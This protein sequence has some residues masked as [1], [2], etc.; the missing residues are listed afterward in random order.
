MWIWKKLRKGGGYDENTL[1]FL[2]VQAISIALG[3]CPEAEGEFPL[4]KIPCT[5]DTGF[6][7][8]N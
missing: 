6:R 7:G 2:T 4:L 3:C 1:F 5:L 8:P